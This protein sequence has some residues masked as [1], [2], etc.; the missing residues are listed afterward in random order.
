M[1]ATYCK[2]GNDWCIR[3]VRVLEPG[4]TIT[5][6]LRSGATKSVTLGQRVGSMHG[7]HVWSVAPRAAAPAQQ[8]GDMQ[9]IVEM[10]D[11][12][13]GRL[14]HPSFILDGFR[15]NVAG[16]RASVPGSITVTA[17]ERGTNG[18]RAWYGR[19]LR[20]GTYEPSNSAPD[21]VAPALRRFAADP[22]GVAAEYGRLH[23]RCCFCNRALDD[24]RSTALGYGPVCAD[25]YGLPHGTVAARNAGTS[26]IDL[27]AALSPEAQAARIDELEREVG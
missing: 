15:V 16:Q 3:T 8:V 12:A 4:D 20:N 25:N 22:A 26:L 5:V 14:R 6:T 1:S 2:F 10:F 7:D 21:N 11:R 27:A 17:A 13:Q 9:R 18:R 24:E 23:G 19:V